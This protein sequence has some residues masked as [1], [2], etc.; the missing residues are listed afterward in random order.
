L[1]ISVLHYRS[2]AESSGRDVKHYSG[3]Q[4]E[5]S[6]GHLAVQPTTT[7]RQSSDKLHSAAGESQKADRTTR[8]Q[9]NKDCSRCRDDEPVLSLT[10]SGETTTSCFICWQKC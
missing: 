7:D 9:K 6:S 5:S 10:H 1:F 4:F 8:L 3:D 2:V